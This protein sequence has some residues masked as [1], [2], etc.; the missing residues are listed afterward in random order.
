M[1]RTPLTAAEADL[2][3]MLYAKEQS[4]HEASAPVADCCENCTAYRYHRGKGSNGGTGRCH[5]EPPQALDN[6]PYT[7]SAAWPPVE[8][9]F[10]CRRHERKK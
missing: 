9:Q 7:S 3:A 6:Q 4:R 8:P 5:A 10:W 2:A 1:D